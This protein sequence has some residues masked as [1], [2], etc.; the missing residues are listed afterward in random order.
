MKELLS[1]LV[2][3]IPTAEPGNIELSEEVASVASSAVVRPALGFWDVGTRVH[4]AGVDQAV[5]GIGATRT[6]G[7]QVFAASAVI[8]DFS[9]LDEKACVAATTVIRVALGF[10]EDGTT[11]ELTWIHEAV[12]GSG[13]VGAEGTWVVAA[14]DCK[15][16]S[17]VNVTVGQ[18]RA[19]LL[20]CQPTSDVERS[21]PPPGAR[22]NCRTPL[23]DLL[24]SNIVSSM[25]SSAVVRSALGIGQAGAGGDLAGIHF[26]VHWV[27]AVGTGGCRVLTAA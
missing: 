14:A 20:C 24:L 26:A 11:G 16:V 18:S 1:G 22:L 2:N 8:G 4:S 6:G 27:G 12:E 21:S 23:S 10:R 3:G 17:G 13:A 25:T 5:N 7:C 19:R 9:V 15:V